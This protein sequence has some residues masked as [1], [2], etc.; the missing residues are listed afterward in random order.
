M[1]KYK[2]FSSKEEGEEFVK[3]WDSNK[4]QLSALTKGKEKFFVALPNTVSLS[5]EKSIVRVENMLKTN[6]NFGMEWIVGR[7]WA[8][9]H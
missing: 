6:V 8:D 7:N 3:N 1:I 9:C 2:I 5:I 4:G